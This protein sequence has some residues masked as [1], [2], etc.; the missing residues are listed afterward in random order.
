M[1]ARGRAIILGL[2]VGVALLGTVVTATATVQAYQNLHAY[3]VRVQAGNVNTVRAWMTIYYISR[4]YRVPQAYLYQQLH[5]AHTSSIRHATLYTL[6]ARLHQ[7][8]QQVIKSIQQ[9]ILGYRQQHAPPSSTQ[10]LFGSATAL[11]G[12]APL[13]GERNGMPFS[14]PNGRWRR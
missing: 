7:P 11:L 8:V 3:S 4:V 6:A 1:S 2:L 12:V 13:T 10:M 5:L 9:A 14:V